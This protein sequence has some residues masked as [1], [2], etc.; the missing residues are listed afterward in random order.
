[1]QETARPKFSLSTSSQKPG[2]SASRNED[3]P[4]IGCER[5]HGRGHGSPK[6]AGF[7]RLL[8]S[9]TGAPLR[10]FRLPSTGN[11]TVHIGKEFAIMRIRSQ[12]DEGCFGGDW[13]DGREEE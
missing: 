11:E 5:L 1:M 9:L 8:G 12:C 10:A 7:Q 6:S 4:A 13:G 2:R 3:R